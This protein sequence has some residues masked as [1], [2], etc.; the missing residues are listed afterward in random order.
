MKAADYNTV[1]KIARY[2]K[3]KV[4]IY[5]QYQAKK[6]TVIEELV[7]LFAEDAEGWKKVIDMGKFRNGFSRVLGVRGMKALKKLL[8]ELDG[9]KYQGIDFEVDN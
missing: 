4:M 1:E 8:N 9:A 2:T 6:S 7:P 3:E 5:R